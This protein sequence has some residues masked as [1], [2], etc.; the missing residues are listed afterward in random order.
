LNVLLV[1]PR[2]Q[3]QVFGELQEP[4]GILSVAASLR[5]AG[6]H[7]EFCDLTFAE[8][9]DALDAPLARAEAVGLSCTTALFGRAL[10]VL[11][12]I[13]SLR[14]ELPVVLGGPHATACPEESLAKGFDAL[15]IGEG[16][17]TAP[18]LF[19]RLADQGDPA[20]MAGVDVLRAGK[21]VTGPPRPFIPDLD[22]LPFPARDLVDYAGYKQN[23]LIHVGLFV[24]RGCPFNCSFCKPMQDKIFGK[25][26]RGR[27]PENVVREMLEAQALIGPRP[28]LFR[29]DT[30]PMLGVPWFQGLGQAMVSAGL[31][32]SRWSCQS[33]VDLIT[34]ELLTVMKQAGCQGIA[35]GVE[36][37][38]QRVLD[39]YQKKIKVEDTI[40]AFDLCREFGIGTHAFMMLGAPIETREDLAATLDLVR[41]IRPNSIS[42]SFTTPAPGSKL[43]LDFSTDG[44]CPYASYE[45]VDYL[46]NHFPLK[47]PHLSREELVA[48]QQALV[49]LVPT[50]YHLDALRAQ[51]ERWRENPRP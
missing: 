13:R 12:R 7:V 33:R 30:L 38:S 36:S 9:L 14:P 1:Y 48:A 5:A 21:V 41:R 22:S 50:T 24:S 37:G 39:F 18:E 32:G 23:N 16:E 19:G 47:H 3:Y 6:F 29:D 46:L 40:R 25:K 34:R 2:F 35:F 11:E 28:F 31:G 26:V 42:T 49:E 15:V 17:V 10:K 44:Q 4:L 27:S 45:D 20:G 43:Y 51:R 8:S